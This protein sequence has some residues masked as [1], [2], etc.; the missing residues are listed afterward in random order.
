MKPLTKIRYL[1][2]MTGDFVNPVENYLIFIKF[3]DE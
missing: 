1:Q 2:K 3:T